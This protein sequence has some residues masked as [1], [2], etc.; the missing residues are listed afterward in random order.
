MTPLLRYVIPYHLSNPIDFLRF[1]SGMPRF[2]FHSAQSS[3]VIAGLGIATQ[4]DADG[5]KRFFH[6][7]Q[8]LKTLR[9]QMITLPSAEEI[10]SP[11][12]FFGASFFPTLKAE[13]WRTFPA[14]TLVLPRYTL[15]QIKGKTFFTINLPLLEGETVSEAA[16]RA[17]YEAEEFLLALETA[18]FPP[19]PPTEI[20]WRE[21]DFLAW[22]NAVQEAVQR[23]ALGDLRKIVL[24]RTRHGM[25]SHSL[26]LPG[27][28]E[29]LGE[30]CSGC[31]RFLFEFQPGHAF[32]GATPEQLALVKG[33]MLSTLALAGST[34]R[35]LTPAEDEALAAGLLASAK[36]Q[37]EHN[38]VVENIRQR[39]A[40]L[41]ERLSIPSTPDVLR[42]P[43][44]QHLRTPIQAQLR[45]GITALDVVAALHPTPAVGGQP[46][47]PALDLIPRLENFSRG[48]YA[49]PIGVLDMDGNADFAVAIRSA[50]VQATHITLFG[51]AGIVTGSEA[52]KEWEE[53]GLKMRFLQSVLEAETVR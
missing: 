25:A 5:H 45:R 10:P 29:R 26:D 19:S 37:H 35:G 30:V 36:D 6:L 33:Q 32:F 15:S 53:T 49:G 16:R 50:L 41:I 31:F 9:Q 7:L 27:V 51:G 18:I 28:L 20:A 38:I 44:I 17:R 4:L 47:A 43:N 2:Y 21:G 46:L 42:L 52:H 22:Q 8:H 1:G 40:T 39:L 3:Q 14:A 24:A 12:L 23:I 48:W 13:E 34:R 11:S